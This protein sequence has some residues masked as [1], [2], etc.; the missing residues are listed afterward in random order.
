MYKETGEE[1]E[2]RKEMLQIIKRASLTPWERLFHNLRVS[3][4]N[5]LFRR[6][7]VFNASYWMGQSV[8]T[9]EAYYIHQDMPDVLDNA[10]AYRVCETDNETTAQTTA[11]SK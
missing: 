8:K 4:S 9:A 7:N 5:E 1:G 2:M 11:Q 6:F 10:L 3:R